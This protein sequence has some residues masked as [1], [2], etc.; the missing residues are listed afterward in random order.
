MRISIGDRDVIHAFIGRRPADSKKL[1][2]DGERLDG[3]WMGG[4]NMAEWAAGHVVFHQT[5]GRTGDQIQRLLKKL[6]PAGVFGGYNRGSGEYWIKEAM[7]TKRR[8]LGLGPHHVKANRVEPAHKG[9]LHRALGVPLGEKIPVE[10]L[11]RAARGG[12]THVARQ[13]RLA[14]TLRRLGR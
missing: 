12:S 3:L 7:G 11:R 4:S 2:T 5:G 13:A 9:A 1:W 10:M 8:H 6:L 14:L